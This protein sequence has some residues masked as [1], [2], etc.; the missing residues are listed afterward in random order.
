MSNVLKIIV[1]DRLGLAKGGACKSL[2]RRDTDHLVAVKDQV[3]DSHVH[4][5]LFL[6]LC[7]AD[8]FLCNLFTIDTRLLIKLL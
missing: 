6:H 5:E 4:L 3:A 8:L 7:D 1:V 2:V